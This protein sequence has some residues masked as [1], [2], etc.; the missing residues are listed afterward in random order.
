MAAEM[1]ESVPRLIERLRNECEGECVQMLAGHL[2]D[3]IPT[4]IARERERWE[5]EV[6]ERLLDAMEN[7]RQGSIGPGLGAINHGDLFGA[8]PAEVE[9]AVGAGQVIQLIALDDFNTALDSIFP[10]DQQ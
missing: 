6:R 7:A 2:E 5:Q 10:G 3:A 1:P 4:A 8:T 9:A